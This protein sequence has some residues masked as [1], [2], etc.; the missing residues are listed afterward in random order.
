MENL[1][2]QLDGVVIHLN[3]LLIKWLLWLFQDSQH[4]GGVFYRLKLSFLRLF[5][6]E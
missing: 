5:L 1:A 4:L 3:G 2:G 6:N